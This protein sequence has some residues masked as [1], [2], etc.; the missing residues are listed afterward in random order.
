MFIIVYIY[1]DNIITLYSA[2]YSVEDVS[3]ALDPLRIVGP[4]TMRHLPHARRPPTG[5]SLGKWFVTEGS[6]D[7]R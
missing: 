4:G 2:S 6:R 3:V 5:S 7:W 1:I